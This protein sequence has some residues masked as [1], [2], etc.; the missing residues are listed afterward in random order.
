MSR[1]HLTI[2]RLYELRSNTV[3]QTLE[4]MDAF[5]RPELFEKLLLVCEADAR[6]VGKEVEYPQANGWRKI[7]NECN[8]ISAKALVQEGFE[9]EAIKIKLHDRR[10][11]MIEIFREKQ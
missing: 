2:H 5:R 4:Q 8:K 11:A 3:V 1:F 9:G 7:L 10:V 6:G